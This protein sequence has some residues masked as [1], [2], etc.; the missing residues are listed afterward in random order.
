MVFGL[1]EHSQ[2]STSQEENAT[3]FAVNDHACVT[4]SFTHPA[5]GARMASRGQGEG[6]FTMDRGK[7]PD[8]AVCY[9]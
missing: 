2:Q 6:R 4:F 5:V 9:V 1:L 7:V 8:C 3:A